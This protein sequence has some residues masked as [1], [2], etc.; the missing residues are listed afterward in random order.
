MTQDTDQRLTAA[1]ESFSGKGMTESQL[2]EAQAIARIL[3]AEI[4]CSGSFFEKLT[5]YSHAF[6]RNGKFDAVRA[7]KM[8]RDTY[9]AVEGQSLNQ[10]REALMANEERIKEAGDPAILLHAESVLQIIQDGPTEPFYK[11]Y[12]QAAVSLAAK[13]S[14]TQ[15]GAKAM[16]KDAFTAKHG[17]DLYEC[18][19]A[20]EE[21]YHKP[22]REAEIAARKA[23]KL[24]TQSQSR[25]YS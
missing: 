4:Q 5:D 23:E 14:I 2:I 22:V 21:A 17:E 6:A 11:A 9:A 1:R 15:N 13:L 16:M 20:A 8:V 3:H 7:E 19:K 25:S 12:D 18:G 24:Q 10:A